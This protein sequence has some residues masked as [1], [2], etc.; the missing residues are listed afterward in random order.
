SKIQNVKCKM[1][2]RG[3][4][5]HGGGNDVYKG[6]GAF[7]VGVTISENEE[8]IVITLDKNVVPKLKV[9]RVLHDLEEEELDTSH[10]EYVSDE[11]QAEIEAI[12]DSMSDEDKEIVY[13]RTVEG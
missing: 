10:L 8:S 9:E 3:R 2:G 1:G 4:G 13:S 11:E 5:E 12:L 7:M 6:K